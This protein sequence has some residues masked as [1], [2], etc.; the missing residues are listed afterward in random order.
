MA[1]SYATLIVYWHALLGLLLVNKPAS[2]LSNESLLTTVN[3]Q[4]RQEEPMSFFSPRIQSEHIACEVW[5]L[6]VWGWLARVRIKQEH[7]LNCTVYAQP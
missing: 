7:H 1:D 3:S 5:P 2:D 4:A 6:I